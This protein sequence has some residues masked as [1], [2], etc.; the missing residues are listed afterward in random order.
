MSFIFRHT[1]NPIFDLF[2]PHEKIISD[3]T[4]KN[5]K[6]LNFEIISYPF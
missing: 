6:M 4:N 5:K 2:R 3:F 1:Y